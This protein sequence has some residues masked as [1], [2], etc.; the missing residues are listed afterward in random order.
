MSRKQVHNITPCVNGPNEMQTQVF[1][2]Y[3]KLSV[4]G[5]GGNEILLSQFIA[6]CSASVDPAQSRMDF[7]SK[8][9]VDSLHSP[10]CA[11]Q[12]LEVNCCYSC[13]SSWES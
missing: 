2:F 10:L 1:Y 9:D 7:E 11:R 6:N 8:D 3:G 12:C 5:G 13:Q 4:E